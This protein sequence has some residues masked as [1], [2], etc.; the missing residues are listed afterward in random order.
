MSKSVLERFL[1][2][3]STGNSGTTGPYPLMSKDERKA[4]LD[5]VLD[6]DN[7]VSMDT[8]IVWRKT[9]PK[10][11]GGAKYRYQLFMN[12][13]TLGGYLEIQFQVEDDKNAGKIKYP[14]AIRGD[15]DNGLEKG[16]CKITLPD[17]K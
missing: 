1:E 2:S 12:K 3:S 8:S 17:K 11:R 14:P 4:L 13:T 9:N 5:K 6:K 10:T 15:L 16:F 7:P